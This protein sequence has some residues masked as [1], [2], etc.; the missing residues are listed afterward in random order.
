MSGVGQKTAAFV[1]VA[2]VLLACGAGG[3]LAYRLLLD[4]PPSITAV[5]AAPSSRLPD[6]SGSPPQPP[7]RKV[8][9]FL[10]DVSIADGSGKRHQL[11]EWKGRLLAVNFWATWCEPCKRE[12]P[13]LKRLRAEHAAQG[14]EVV[15]IA[16]DL[17]PAVLKYEQEAQIDYPVLIGQQ[18]G[19]A[20]VTELGM[21]TVLPFTVFAD[22]QGRVITLKIGE[23]RPQEAALI[24][25]RVRDL[26]RGRL[27]LS[28]ARKQIA[29]GIAALAAQRATP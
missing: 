4:H 18:D 8:P 11:S 22:R 14:L 29:D 7:A 16:I 5:P 9:E 17:L 25:D 15:G 2:A 19:L 6:D 21:D 28:L 27:S 20:A 1:A 10:P 3:F 26:D 23:L 13:L 24:F 12:I